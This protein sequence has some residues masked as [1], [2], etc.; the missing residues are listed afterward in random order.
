MPRYTDYLNSESASN[1]YNP[2]PGGFP[3]L[4]AGR[5]A[6]I[7][8]G[9]VLI[10][11]AITSR[12]PQP[13]VYTGLRGM[14]KTVVLER[15]LGLA[16]NERAIVLF[17]EAS[18]QIPLF[19]RL[20]ETV[21][22]Q[23]R[24]SEGAPKKIARALEGV[25]AA[26]PRAKYELPHDMGAVT[27]EGQ[28][29]EEE[30]RPFISSLADL[31]FEARRHGRF[32]VIGIDEVQEA[33]SLDLDSLISFVHATVRTDDPVMFLAAGL[34]NSRRHLYDVRTYTERYRYV[35]LSYLNPA[36]TREAIEKPAADLGVTVEPA[37][38]DR[39]VQATA[40]YPYFIQQFASSAWEAHRG[41]SI[42]LS[43]A[44]QAIQMTRPQL[45]AQFYG[46]AFRRLTPRECAYVLAMQRLGPGEHTSGEIA[47]A[48]GVRSD[49]ISSIRQRLVEKDVIFSPSP[50]TVEFRMP[51]S[52]DY[53]EE[54]RALL[55][56]RASDAEI[57]AAL[58]DVNRV[59]PA[60]E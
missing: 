33:Q 59:E 44:D 15:V 24:A 29:T 6:A 36:D 28:K 30:S 47:A 22:T 19:S 60:Q 11:R 38:L 1:P 53:I 31:N 56:R 40:G 23:L 4:L 9:A 14:G 52:E 48:L 58:L 21:Q 49:Q 8:A 2:G 55:E 54:H 3:P 57:S 5:N 13:V 34:P 7:T 45:D 18:R 43:D 17:A 35:E 25:L 41:N 51:L 10:E 42:T 46:P 16:R 50:G 37:A 20:R 39:L 27:L 12:P 26:L 32:L